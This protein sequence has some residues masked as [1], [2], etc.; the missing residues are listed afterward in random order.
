MFKK[1]FTLLILIALLAF[2]FYLSWIEWVLGSVLLLFAYFVLF[3]AFH[4]FFSYLRKKE[5][6]KIKEFIIYFFYRLSV[7]IFLLSIFFVWFVYF[8][9]IIEPALLPEITIS[10]WKKTV[11]FQAMAHIWSNSFYKEIRSNIR[12]YKKKWYV[13]FYEW[14]RSW[15]KENTDK[16]DKLMWLKF[17]KQT[18][19]N[20][21][22]LYNLRAQ[23]NEEFFKIENNLDFNADISIDDIINIYEKKYWAVT[24]SASN[25][26]EPVEIGKIVQETVDS[27]TPNEL[28]LMIQLNRAMMNVIMKNDN[29]RSTIMELSDKNDLF[30]V[31]LEDRN[32]NLVNKINESEY[33]KIYITYWLMHFEWIWSSLQR[34]DPNWKL[35]SVRYFKPIK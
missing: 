1:L 18:Y 34:Q 26:E 24:S 30:D 32:K 23:N 13:Y 7:F 14:V 5:S 9:N 15:S 8:E 22:K 21:S 25:K 3:F 10:N 6:L 4:K 28:K 17:N 33:N 16:F 12:D 11:V 29:I 35:V 27:L 2:N 20:V 31:I 19:V